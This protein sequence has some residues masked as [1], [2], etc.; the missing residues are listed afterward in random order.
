MDGFFETQLLR[1]TVKKNG[2]RS[3]KDILGRKEIFQPDPGCI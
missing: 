2:D 3:V 1:A